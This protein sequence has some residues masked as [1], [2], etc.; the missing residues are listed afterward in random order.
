M[1]ILTRK[2]S[3]SFLMIVGICIA[4]AFLWP[5]NIE[6]N[7]CAILGN[8]YRLLIYKKRLI[9]VDEEKSSIPYDS[10]EAETWYRVDF[11]G[12]YYPAGI[13]GHLGKFYCKIKINTMNNR[14]AD[15]SCK[16]EVQELWQK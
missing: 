4:I 11:N 3:N 7:G 13:Y 1:K 15:S 6:G 12:K 2:F 14:I 9:W 8:E 5:R 16:E 10:I